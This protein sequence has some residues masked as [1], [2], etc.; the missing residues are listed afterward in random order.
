[1]L[2]ALLSLRHIYRVGWA[3]SSSTPLY[4]AR[5]SDIPSCQLS[6]IPLRRVFETAVFAGSDLEK[7]D[8]SFQSDEP[9]GTLT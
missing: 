5:A 9:S 4:T 1:M 8:P 3:V 2:T 6:A 7:A